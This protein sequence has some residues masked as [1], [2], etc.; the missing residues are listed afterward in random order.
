MRLPRTLRTVT[1][2]IS[3]A[4]V[5]HN[6]QPV[7][8]FGWVIAEAYEHAYLPMLAALDRHPGIRAGLHYTGPLL[9]WFRAERPDFL[10]RLAALVKRGQVELLG[11]GYYEPVLAIL[12]E[13]DRIAQLSRMADEIERI[14]GRRPAGT[15][16]AERVWEPDLP[17]SIVDSGYAWTVLDD[18]HFRAAGLGDGELWGP[19]TTEDQG[20]LL[21]V[22]GSDR[23]LRY[24]IPFGQVD[25]MIGHLVENAT[26]GGERLGFMGDDGEK[27]GAWPYTYEHCWGAESWIE[28]F[29]A[30]V[31]AEPAIATVSP[32]AWLELHRPI[33]RIYLPTSSYFE[34]GEWALPADQGLAF[35]AAVRLAEAE[36]APWGRWLRGGYWRNFQ[37]K[38]REVNDLHKQMLRASDAVAEMQSGAGADL[39]RDHLH[40]G[41]SNDCYWHGLF[42]GVYIPHM[43]LA[44]HEH[45][46]AAAD[47]ADQLARRSGD[48][49]TTVLLDTDLDGIDEVLMESDGQ[50]IIIDPTEGGGLGAWD[51]RAVRHALTAVMRR[52]PEAY[53][54]RLLAHEAALAAFASPAAPTEAADTPSQPTASTGPAKGPTTIHGAVRSREPEL[55]RHLHYDAYERRSGL[56]H[57]LRPGT[58][59]VAFA[60]GAA[61][62]LGDS[63]V[64]AYELIAM[65]PG[66]VVLARDVAMS[67]SSAIV[68]V[69]KRFGAGGDRRQPTLDLEVSVEALAGA[70]VRFDLAVEWS[71]TMLGGGRN[72]AAYYVV[73][74]E[75]LN[76]D[77]S[78]QR[79]GL[80]TIVS[81]N[82]YIGIEL[83]T[84][85]EPATTTWWTPIETI[86]N[87]EYGFE[88]VYQ[89]SALTF[90]WPIDLAAGERRTVAVRNVIATAVDRSAEE[91]DRSVE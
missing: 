84:T 50:V 45:L 20:R 58:S 66:R 27:F 23:R 61:T 85:V 44:T 30:A 39:A 74:G 26:P 29:F 70:P 9:D 90:V 15:W 14:G 24:G 83:E 79:S 34:M 82:E 57:L 16:L 42:G 31:E 59:S 11:G 41:Q 81:G 25:D 91:L 63:V 38:Y 10:D 53:H 60:D 7:G 73:D 76:H 62:E 52:R 18:A 55:A 86:S 89:G 64:G 87:S 13:R 2:R 17:T 12:P 49:D 69:E 22:F 35:E 5:L 37:I 80:A 51:I 33:G 72:P 36:G 4:L 43:R 40:Q 68:R 8:N 1:D 77:S 88:R 47:L 54:A 19:Y 32:T 48:T 67:D 65:G 46:I 56:V 78:G 75:R 3:L 71:L 28:R 21:T 6:H